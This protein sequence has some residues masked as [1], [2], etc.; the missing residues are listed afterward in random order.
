MIKF[1][2]KYGLI[3]EMI[4]NIEDTGIQFIESRLLWREEVKQK[5]GSLR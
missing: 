2:K 3:P 4:K 5:R 1:E